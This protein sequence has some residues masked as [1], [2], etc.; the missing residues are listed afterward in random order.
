M[1]RGP[2]Q[3]QLN[4]QCCLIV[5]PRWLL[6]HSLHCL[7]CS[8]QTS[9][10]LLSADDVMPIS[11]K[12]WSSSSSKPSTWVPHLSLYLYAPVCHTGRFSTPV[13]Y[14]S[15]HLCSRPYCLLCPGT[16]FHQNHPLL[17]SVSDSLVKLPFP[18]SFTSAS[19]ALSLAI[20]E[21]T[22]VHSV[23]W[24]TFLDFLVLDRLLSY[25][26]HPTRT[27]HCDSLGSSQ[28][29]FLFPFATPAKATNIS[30]LINATAY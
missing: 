4:S 27:C 13:S 9:Y 20:M 30:L 25:L 24:A 19:P 28:L 15:L 23:A 21:S 3:C 10:P 26:L 22:T 11:Q 18:P 8:L 1:G 2:F 6:F 5:V 17:W 16:T 14:K 29:C 7:C 12:L